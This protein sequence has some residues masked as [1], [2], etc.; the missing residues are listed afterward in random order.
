MDCGAHTELVKYI[1]A[2]EVPPKDILSGNIYRYEQSLLENIS[3]L[4]YNCDMK[5]GVLYGGNSALI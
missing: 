3:E 1:N 5:G 2:T 4:H